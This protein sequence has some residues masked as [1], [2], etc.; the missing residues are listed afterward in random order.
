MIQ[1]QSFDSLIWRHSFSSYEMRVFLVIARRA[2][3]LASKQP[4]GGVDN[5]CSADGYNLNFVVPLRVLCGEKTHN[6]EPLKA[7][8]RGMQS[9][10][11]VEYWDRPS[12]VWRSSSVIYNISIE[13]RSG[14]CRFSAAKWVVEMMADYKRGGYRSYD[15][16]TAMSLSSPVS[17]RLYMLMASRHA[18]WRISLVELKKL[19]GLGD[20]YSRVSDFGSK[21]LGRSAKELEARGLG[22]YRWAYVHEYPDNPRSAVTQVQFFPPSNDAVA[23]S[24]AAG[25]GMLQGKVDARLM[26]YLVSQYSVTYKEMA[27]NVRYMSGFGRLPGWEGKIIDICKRGHRQHKG[28]GWLLRA[29]RSEVLKAGLA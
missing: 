19:L 27:A 6:Y 20:R 5:A 29:I 2:F 8:L 15:F 10:W 7:A 23:L 11:V 13:A 18:P 21:V 3:G 1:R 17:A 22:V 24:E 9:G 26:Q 4:Q 25:V 14:L 16:E 28:K 12:K